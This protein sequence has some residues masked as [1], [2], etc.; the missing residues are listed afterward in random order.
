MLI[1]GRAVA[2]AG[3]AG[4]GNGAMTILA[5]ILPPREQAIFM[6]LNMGLGQIGLALGPVLGGIFTEYLSWSW[7]TSSIPFLF[8]PCFA[9]SWLRLTA[10]SLIRF[11]HKSSNRGRGGYIAILPSDP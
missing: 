9:A 3:S 5:A 10:H 6:G 4:I 7:C 1:V 2:G 11:L 8:S